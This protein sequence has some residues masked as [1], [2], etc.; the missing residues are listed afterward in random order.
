MGSNRL[1]HD[2]R[3][4]NCLKSSQT[5]LIY[6]SD[7]SL[8]VTLS[9]KMLH[10]S[11]CVKNLDFFIDRDLKYDYHIKEAVDEIFASNFCS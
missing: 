6:F 3:K 4:K 10:E 2:S 9:S 8:D 7:I 11:K 1:H 5:H